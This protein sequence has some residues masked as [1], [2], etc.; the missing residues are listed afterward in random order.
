VRIGFDPF[1][2]DLET[3]RLTREVARFTLRLKHM[4]SV[5]IVWFAS[6]SH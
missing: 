3:S 5:V 4:R 2:L 6:D 1:T